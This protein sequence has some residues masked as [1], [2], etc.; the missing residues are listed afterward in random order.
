MKRIWF[1][2]LLGVLAVTGLSVESFFWVKQVEAYQ[3]ATGVF[4]TVIYT[5]PI[6]VRAGPSTVYYPDVI[7]QLN[8]GDIVPALGV[9]P[10]REWIQIAYPA[11]PN[12]AGW[13]YAIYVS[14]SGGE[15]HVV[16]APGTRT[17]AITITIDATLAAQ[18][19]VEPTAS[20]IP[21]FTPPPP[22]TVPHYTEDLGEPHTGVAPGFYV[23]GL[24][25][26]GMLGL[27]T[28]LFWRR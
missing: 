20:R 12:G 26:I 11:A 27:I 6:N 21:T 9:S 4:A 25:L 17:P 1:K 19:N 18:F 22:L 7:G 28:S 2:T 14:I 10:G 8:P 5:E 3:D 15:L 13:V 16:E 23:L 24:A